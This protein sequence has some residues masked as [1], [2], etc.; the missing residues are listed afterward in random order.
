MTRNFRDIEWLPDLA[1]TIDYMAKNSVN[2]IAVLERGMGEPHVFDD[3]IITQTIRS[4]TK[5][6]EYCTQYGEQLNWWLSK[7]LDLNQ[8]SEVKR[9][10]E[11]NQRVIA[12]NERILDLCNQI[13]QGTIDRIMEKDDADLAF[14]VLTGQGKSSF[15]NSIHKL[16]DGLE[17]PSMSAPVQRFES[18]MAIHQFVESILRAGGGDDEIINDPEM[19]KFAMQYIGILN[20]AQPVEMDKLKQMFSGFDRFAVVF[21]TLMSLM[22]N[23]Q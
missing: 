7:D 23:F 18:A 19:I 22:K 1:N 16:M 14:E 15:S 10:V 13:K 3:R 6:I 5:A 8:R 20:S 9:L 4:Y 17:M 12:L 2:Q 21:E 11:A